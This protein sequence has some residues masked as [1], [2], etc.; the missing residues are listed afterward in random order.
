MCVYTL[1]AQNPSMIA[2]HSLVESQIRHANLAIR[3]DGY[4]WPASCLAIAH[5]QIY[6]ETIISSVNPVYVGNGSEVYNTDIY[7]PAKTHLTTTKRYFPLD[8][9]LHRIQYSIPKNIT[10]HYII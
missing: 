2:K 1:F 9:I 8:K 6:L 10:I 3:L 7:V 5:M 4:V